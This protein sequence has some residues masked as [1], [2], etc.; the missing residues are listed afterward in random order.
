MFLGKIL[1]LGLLQIV[2]IL[3]S[4]GYFYFG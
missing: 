1:E 4:F 2:F 3:H